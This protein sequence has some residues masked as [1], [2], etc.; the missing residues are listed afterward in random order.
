MEITIL[1][2]YRPFGDAEEIK[3]HIS[4]IVG[5][6]SVPHTY[7]LR[8]SS[9]ESYTVKTSNK[10]TLP[11]Y[12]LYPPTQD[13]IVNE[14]Q[15][16]KAASNHISVN[17]CR[18]PR[19]YD[20]EVA[21]KGSK[22]TWTQGGILRKILDFSS[23][24]EVIHQTLFA[25]FI[26]NSPSQRADRE[27]DREKEHEE[28]YEVGQ[29]QFAEKRGADR[30]S[31]QQALVI[32]LKETAKIY[33]P[34]GES[35]SIHLPFGVHRVWAMDLGL[36]MERKPD[37]GEE[38]SE[39]MEGAGLPRFYMIM[40]PFNEL[41]IVTLYQLPKPPKQTATKPTPQE[42]A[43][44]IR[45]MNGIVGDIFNTCVFLSNLDAS[46]RTVVTFDL[47]S[48]R[49]RV[50]R[51]ASSMLTALPFSRIP[52]QPG[53]AGDTAME[54]DDDVDLQMRT[55]TYLF[56]IE[57]DIQGASRNSTIFGAHAFDGST[58]IGVLDHEAEKISCYQIIADQIVVH[59]WTKPAVSAAAVEATRKQLR[60]ILILSHKGELQLWTGF[61]SE[62]VPC[63]ANVEH[64]YLK[65][66]GVK[67]YAKVE[68]KGR[69][70]E[71]LGTENTAVDNDNQKMGKPADIVEIRDAVENRVSFVLKD[72][73]V[74]RMQLDFVI[75][76]SLVQE[77]LDAITYAL[78]TDA[79]WDF[80]HRFLQLH[81]ERVSKEEEVFAD[82]WNNFTTTLLSYCG[83]SFHQSVMSSPKMQT[84][85][86]SGILKKPVVN[87]SDWD[88][89]LDSDIHRLM[90]THPSFRNESLALPVSDSNPYMGM[91]MQAQKLATLHFR[92][93]ATRQSLRLDWFYPYVLVALH[94]VYEDRNLN[95][96][97]RREGD[98][99]PLL[100]LISHIVKWETWVDAYS[101]SDF[102]RHKNIELPD[103]LRWISDFVSHPKE[104]KSFPTLASL[105]TLRDAEQTSFPLLTS[106][107]CEQ[108]RKV[109]HFFTSLMAGDGGDQSVVRAIVDEGFTRSQLDQLPFGVSVPL[110]EAL[111]KCR[112]NPSPD[113]NSNA[114]SFIGRND[115]AELASEKSPGYYMKPPSQNK[116]ESTKRLDI[117]SLC[118]GVDSHE[119]DGELETTGAEITESDI[120]NLRFGADMR[121]AETQKMLRSSAVLRVKPEETPDLSEEDL[122]A[123][124]QELLCKLATRTLALP[125]GRGILTFGTATPILNQK[126]PIPPINLSAKILPS[127]GIMEPD[128]SAL[129]G[130]QVLNWPDFHNGVAAGLR[131][132]PNSTDVTSSW[133]TYNIPEVLNSSHAGFLFALGLTGHLRA[134]V[135]SHVWRY[136]SFKHE[137]TS[138]G[139]LLGLACAHRGTMNTA[140]TR[141]LSVHIPALLPQHGSELNLSPITQVASVLGIGL[142]Y[143]ETSHR[144]M[145]EVMLSEVGSASGDSVDSLNSLQE[146]HSVSAG[147]GLGFITLGQGNK[148]MGLRDMKIVD[149]LVSYMP[150]TTDKNHGVRSLADSAQGEEY[151]WNR[152]QAGIDMT[153][154]GATVAMGLMY[155]KTNSKSIA[156]KL[157]VPE[158]QFLLDYV[159]PDL[160]M[161]RVICKAIVLWDSIIPTKSWV[162]SQIPDYLKDIKTNGPPTTETGP[163]SYYSILAGACFAMG[164]RFAGSGNEAAYE[165]ILKHLDMF[166][167]LARANRDGSYEDSITKS[168]IRTC[169]DVTT[170]SVAM[171]VAGSGRIDFLR[172][173]RKLARRT[174][175]D[176]TYGSHLAYHMALGLLFL[177]GGGY[178]LGTSNRC[179]AALLCSLYPRLPSSPM[180]NRSHLQ[181]FRHLWVL[182]AEPRCLVTR[183]AS[184]GACCPVPVRVHLKAEY[185][186]IQVQMGLGLKNSVDQEIF[187]ADQRHPDT[188]ITGLNSNVSQDMAT[189]LFSSSKLDMMTP[190]LLPELS[191][192]SKIEILGPRYWP[193]TIDLSCE[194][195]DYSRIWRFL[196]ARSISVMRHTGHLSYTEDPLGMRGI[197]A[198]PFPK[199]LTN[200]ELGET[201]E[202]G[203]TRSRKQERLQRL[204]ETRYE[205]HVGGDQSSRTPESNQRNDPSYQDFDKSSASY[206]EDFCLTFLQDPQVASFA[207]HL[208]RAVEDDRGNGRGMRRDEARAT[209][210]TNVLYE[211]L[212][213]DKVEV[214][215]VH[216]W[217]Y[218][219]ANRLESLDELSRR[220][221][222]E[223]R[224]LANYYDAQFKRRLIE[225][226]E[227]RPIGNHTKKKNR[228]AIS[229][230]DKVLALSADVMEDDGSETLIKVSRVTELVSKITKRVEQAMGERRFD[231]EQEELSM[232][233][234]ARDYFATGSLPT[235]QK[236]QTKT[237]TASSLRSGISA[238]PKSRTNWFKV[239]LELNEV[240]GP[241][242][243][244][245]I[246]KAL[247]NTRDCWEYYVDNQYAQVDSEGGGE[248]DRMGNEV[249]VESDI[250][251]EH[252]RQ[253]R[254]RGV[255]TLSRSVRSASNMEE[256]RRKLLKQVFSLAY[257]AVSLKVLDFVIASEE[258]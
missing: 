92:G 12:E 18:S 141:V 89:F 98:M 181:A 30:Q 226:A 122:R 13:G 157:G 208:C 235:E 1:G 73:T 210:F 55:D 204:A 201:T 4:H 135:R 216:V 74:L 151:G 57:S 190:C 61:S 145:A 84:R 149:V 6:S 75:R 217:L 248:D 81:F 50:W 76:S 23:D 21:V 225:K 126:C 7:H 209:Y 120:T 199:V 134:L 10:V 176:T 186:Q 125:V 54:I 218:D 144:R 3:D 20:V 116:K 36:L 130:D 219:I 154:A 244:G 155:L 103:I 71:T 25:W 200:E 5:P 240:P 212:T 114:L 24:N 160:L 11:R 82:E 58:V 227:Q 69:Q 43:P 29:Q 137:L 83:P 112:R 105:A 174:K 85:T 88:F 96:V 247:S 37:L 169:L 196:K 152:R 131:I 138:T 161:L 100:T 250:G 147:F 27:R 168:V 72:N 183:D 175:G 254:R 237:T 31:R 16:V 258:Q 159:T 90:K 180:D 167:D 44:R 245:A 207:S 255:H 182:A 222:W 220:T 184:T 117:H 256:G 108:I 60:D 121:V 45:H 243:I 9:N 46:D 189:T 249:P 78:P 129:G 17:R 234:I 133:I 67:A 192:I 38:V 242:A 203:S 156:S 239:W 47:L 142:I 14:T 19:G 101:R 106:T 70:S 171:V 34:S 62:F 232:Y 35:Y 214:L 224:I 39:E 109:T 80:K 253:K 241:A 172:R 158:T 164:L 26:I 211:C 202:K 238:L 59:L 223:L 179:V 2:E 140:I 177:G 205:W 198:R 228:S 91:I 148:S 115:L 113:L 128:L 231:P 22:A 187:R 49:H 136:L 213:M 48:K 162:L 110:R 8:E 163:Q 52:T 230:S 94:L 15:E 93:P 33:F 68:A 87:D 188:R 119:G 28:E 41:Q 166:I 111:W 233:M 194:T 99:V 165:C 102:A 123:I 104:T 64:E 86:L 124:H 193:I 150:G 40:D 252:P 195:E 178:T 97:T 107:P 32:V 257:P 51:Y 143:M 221:L 127:F 95:L 173:L 251:L 236:N 191:L 170:M 206:G 63:H 246:K 146:C 153:S 53:F 66:K 132:S 118:E 185:C 65:S 77:C 215:G 229:S 56:E 197:L 139:L 79:L 42:E